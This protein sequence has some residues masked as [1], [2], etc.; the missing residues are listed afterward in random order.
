MSIVDALGVGFT[1]GFCTGL[2][3]CAITLRNYR[4]I[5]RTGQEG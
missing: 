4:I 5:K 1:L 3:Y 2:L